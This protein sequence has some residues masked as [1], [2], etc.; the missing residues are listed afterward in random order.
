MPH[1]VGDLKR[2]PSYPCIGSKPGSRNLGLEFTVYGWEFLRF[3][4]YMNS[5]FMA[6]S[7]GLGLPG[8]PI[9]VSF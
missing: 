8:D 9:P 2:D 3:G 4:V 7:L 1:Y 6:L 5:G